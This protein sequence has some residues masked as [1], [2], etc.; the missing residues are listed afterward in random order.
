MRRNYTYDTALPFH[1]NPRIQPRTRFD[2]ANM[3]HRALVQLEEAAM[4]AYH[5]PA[6]DAVAE[7][8]DAVRAAVQR[9]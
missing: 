9:H 5:D 3:N 1:H 4:L 7:A 8:T 2:L 6:E